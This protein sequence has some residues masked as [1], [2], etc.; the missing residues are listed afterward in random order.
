MDTENRDIAEAR[1][2]LEQ[3]RIVGLAQEEKA[4]EVLRAMATTLQQLR[5]AK[6][7][8][9]GE[10]ARRYAVAITEYEKSLAFFKYYVVERL[11][12]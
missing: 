12:R 7:T 8:E 1:Q 3:E 9:R 2:Q 11:N 4:K 6:P 10:L 5:D